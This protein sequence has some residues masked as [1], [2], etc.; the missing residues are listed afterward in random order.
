MTY[1][2]IAS[3]AVAA[4]SLA[5]VFL[6]G[7]GSS[8]ELSPAVSSSPAMALELMDDPDMIRARRELANAMVMFSPDPRPVQT[9]TI[10]P[11]PPPA[12][13]EKERNYFVIPPPGALKPATAAD[14]KQYKE[15]KVTIDHSPCAKNPERKRKV[16]INPHQ[17]RCM[18]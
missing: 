10:I 13:T 17:W 1:F 18:K 15:S 5:M 3:A 8:P 2:K 4:M 16:W 11:T 12:L 7:R 6:A 14:E 9:E